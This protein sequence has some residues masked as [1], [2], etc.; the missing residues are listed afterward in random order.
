MICANDGHGVSGEEENERERR[1]V[2]EK[3]FGTAM[4]LGVL[5]SEVSRHGRC[6]GTG[7][8]A[9]R[10]ARAVRD[11]AAQPESGRGRH[12]RGRSWFEMISVVSLG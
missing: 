10:A 9:I 4:T 11:V 3:G 1:A 2:V 6:P 12:I 7:S 8:W 5:A